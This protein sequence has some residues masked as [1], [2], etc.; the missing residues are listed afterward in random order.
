MISRPAPGLRRVPENRS[1][2]TVVETDLI[3]NNTIEVWKPRNEKGRTSGI[4]EAVMSICRGKRRGKDSGGTRPRNFLARG[5]RM[6]LRVVPRV[7]L[8]LPAGTVKGF[9]N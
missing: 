5:G 1:T 3:M 8:P 4:Q 6:T 7:K 2:L 9:G